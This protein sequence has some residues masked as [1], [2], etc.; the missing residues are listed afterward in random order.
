M[1]D[2]R[3]RPPPPAWTQPLLDR[4]TP[5]VRNLI[6]A[7]TVGYF[8]FVL[9]P[10]ASA[11]IASHL[12]VGPGLFHGEVWQ[13]LTAIF[14]H[15]RFTGWFFSVIGLWWVG[16]FVERTRGP[17]FF[18]GL[19]FGAGVAA[20]VV[21]AAVSFL[22]SGGVGEVRS[23][24]AGFALSATFV[25]FARIYGPRPAQIW[26]AFSMRADYF[27]WILIGF[28]LVISL[29][30]RDLAG[31]AAEVTAIAIALAATGGIK[32]LLALRRR[33]TRALNRSRYRVLDGGKRP[34]PTRLN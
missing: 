33:S 30:N 25:A 26:G 12:F 15:A 1:P 18:L 8:F 2:P 23:D 9:A 14:L 32:D 19:F 29:V 6:I 31:F 17:R 22:M 34:P 5:P 13:P 24:G 28:S 4:L 16:A 27:T 10:P 20:N 3:R 11:W 21:A 7:L